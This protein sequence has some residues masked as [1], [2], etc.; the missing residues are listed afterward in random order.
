M[1][2]EYIHKFLIFILYLALSAQLWGLWKAEPMLSK[3]YNYD[4]ELEDG[5][6]RPHSKLKMCHESLVFALERCT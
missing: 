1:L 3:D 2:P 5:H 6:P 4:V